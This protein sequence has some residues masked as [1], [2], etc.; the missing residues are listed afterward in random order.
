MLNQFVTVGKLENSQ[1]MSKERVDITLKVARNYKNIKG[2][3]DEDIITIQLFDKMGQEV[4]KLNAG[5]IL[6]IKGRIETNN[7]LISEKL[8]FLSSK[9]EE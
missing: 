9:G 1:K 5:C 6:G 3:V 8:T 7:I 2:E 4:L